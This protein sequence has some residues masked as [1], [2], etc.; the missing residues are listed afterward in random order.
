MGCSGYQSLKR[1]EYH[2]ALGVFVILSLFQRVRSGRTRLL[3]PYFQLKESLMVRCF[4]FATVVL[5]TLSLNSGCE[6]QQENTVLPVRQLSQEQQ[7]ED[8]RRQ[9]MMQEMEASR[10][11]GTYDPNATVE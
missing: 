6:G 7:K 5:F 2:I 1:N 9:R 4:V 8:D 3:T 11:N 10:R